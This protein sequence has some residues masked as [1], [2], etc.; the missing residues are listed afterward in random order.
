LIRPQKVVK[1]HGRKNWR[2]AK[3]NSMGLRREGSALNEVVQEN[4]I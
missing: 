2:W 3:H 1:S 4:T